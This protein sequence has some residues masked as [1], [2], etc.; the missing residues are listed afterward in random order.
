[1]AVS[2]SITYTL[3]VAVS[4]SIKTK[5]ADHQVPRLVDMGVG[6]GGVGRGVGLVGGAAQTG[7]AKGG[8]VD[9]RV[10]GPTQHSC[11]GVLAPEHV[12]FGR[13]V[14]KGS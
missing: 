1:M 9:V 2:D 12:K 8:R 7:G 14:A 3:N 11:H 4:D 13:S 10:L 6:V 5:Q